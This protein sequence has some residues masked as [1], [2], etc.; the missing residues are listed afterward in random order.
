MRR[1]FAL[2][3][4]G[5]ALVAVAVAAVTVAVFPRESSNVQLPAIRVPA[6]PT[7]RPPVAVSVDVGPI[8]QALTAAVARGGA[9]IPTPGNAGAGAG[10]VGFRGA[11]ARSQIRSTTRRV[12]TPAPAA[13]TVV[14]RQVSIGAVSGPNGDTGLA[15]GPSPTASVGASSGRSP[16]GD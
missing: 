7:P 10:V 14:K 9:A 2:W 3:A 15:G 12:A 6:R 16:V 1:S 11:T 13:K 4:G 5:A 8:G